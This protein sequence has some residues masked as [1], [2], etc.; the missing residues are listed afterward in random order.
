MKQ[1]EQDEKCVFYF[2]YGTEFGHRDGAGYGIRFS[3]ENTMESRSSAGVSLVCGLHDLHEALSTKKY[4]F[5][6]LL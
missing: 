4:L 6:F 5:E 3:R 2:H 1:R